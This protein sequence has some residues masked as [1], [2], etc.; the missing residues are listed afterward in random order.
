LE[1][2]A[3]L[4]R[5]TGARLNMINIV[6][7]AKYFMIGDPA[8]FALPYDDPA[9]IYEGVRDAVNKKLHLLTLKPFMKGI[10]CGYETIV[11]D[12][13][14][15]EI[16][17]YAQK[18]NAAIIVMGSHGTN[19]LTDILLGSTSERVVRKAGCPVLVISHKVKMPEFKLIVF[20]SDFK[21][22]AFDVF[23]KIQSFAKISGAEIHLLKVN[24]IEQFSSTRENEEA[25]VRFN[26]HFKKKYKTV[27]YDDYM[28]EYGILDYANE[29]KADLIAVGTHG[30]KGLARFFK[31]D[32][33]AG[34]V[35][36]ANIPIFIANFRPGRKH[37]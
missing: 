37:N 34:M 6:Q 2:A 26:R 22:E 31:T 1:Y 33:P 27:I 23:P 21:E 7:E 19:G 17:S 16:T 3:W 20:A 4:A 24:T 5:K 18:N 11:G 30:K 36:L 35:R 28:K 25:M 32:I 15:V 9:K 8:A 29:V 12:G 10:N 14:H 13:T